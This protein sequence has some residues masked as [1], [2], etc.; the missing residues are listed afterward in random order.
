MIFQKKFIIKGR[1]RGRYGRF[2]KAVNKIISGKKFKK[3]ALRLKE[4]VNALDGKKKSAEINWN[5]IKELSLC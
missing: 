1:A 4:R 5:K 3:A 2:I